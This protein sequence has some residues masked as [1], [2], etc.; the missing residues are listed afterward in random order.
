MK[1][2]VI[3]LSCSDVADTNFVYELL[4]AEI[5]QGAK[6]HT[7]PILVQD[8]V[9]KIKSL[10]CGSYQSVILERGSFRSKSISPLANHTAGF[11][12]QISNM[13]KQY[14]N[15]SIIV[16]LLCTRERY[17]NSLHWTRYLV[18]YLEICLRIFGLEVSIKFLHPAS[19]SD[20]NIPNQ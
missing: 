17:R 18:L 4:P 13:F 7:Y 11:A 20:R 10:R 6:A 3:K 15:E 19:R 5:G 9:I 1:S 14:C 16:N 12:L 8:M 2:H